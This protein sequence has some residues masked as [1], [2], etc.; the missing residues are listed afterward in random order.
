[1]GCVPAKCDVFNDVDPA[2]EGNGNALQGVSVFNETG[3][4]SFRP[5]SLCENPRLGDIPEKDVQVE[6]ELGD[7]DAD[8]ILNVDADLEWKKLVS[9]IIGAK[10]PGEICSEFH[11][12]AIGSKAICARDIAEDQHNREELRQ[13]RKRRTGELEHLHELCAGEQEDDVIS[14]SASRR[15]H[16]KIS[17]ISTM[18]RNVSERL[19]LIIENPRDMNIFY[20]V[21]SLVLGKGTY[22]VVKRATI[23]F[24]GAQRAIKFISKEASK[25]TMGNLKSEIDICKMLDHPN[26]VKLYEVFEDAEHLYLVM[27]LCTGDHLFS[28]LRNTATMMEGNAALAMRQ[29]FRGVAYMH[30]CYVCHRD[31]KPQNILVTRSDLSKDSNSLRIS[32][33]GLSCV[34]EPGQYL[35]AQVGTTAYMAP[36]V[37]ERKYDQACD[38]WSCGVILHVLL[39]GYLPFLGADAT[40]ESIRKSIKKAKLRLTGTHWADLSHICVE[41]VGELLKVNPS[42]RLT[43]KGALDHKWLQSTSK[44]DDAPASPTKS[45]LSSLAKFRQQN[46]FKKAAQHLVVSLLSDAQTRQSRELFMRIDTDGDGFVSVE[47]LVQYYGSASVDEKAFQS[48]DETDET[49]GFSYTEFLAATMNKRQCVQQNVCKA[50]YSV[51]DANGDE[52]LTL[53]ELTCGQSLLGRLSQDEAKQLVN[54][55]DRNGDGMIDFNEFFAMMRG[56]LK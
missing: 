17:V 44:K 52:M 15:T 12:S 46:K 54:D 43:A 23:R 53:D 27:E 10:D 51:F 35:T 2:N 30:A 26:V 20:D 45:I 25:E 9:P 42:Q 37:L 50:A 41:I 38:I 5:A 48:S 6:Y 55:L 8:D 32:D 40:K 28:L 18:G 3:D 21:D 24:T 19:K 16:S 22:G 14:R 4:L 31:L 56:S 1:M 47:E 33:F 13:E 49:R 29:I 34:F 36:Q 39:C 11:L 7:E